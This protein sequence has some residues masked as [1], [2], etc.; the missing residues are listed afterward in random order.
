MTTPPTGTVTLLF[1]DIEGSTKLLQRAGDA[2]TDLLAVHRRLLREVFDAQNGY[3]VDTQGDAFFVAFASVRDAVAA[4]AGAQQALAAH[5]WP[6]HCEVSVRIGVHTGEPQLVEGAYVG[7]DV[8]H[9]ARVM[10]AGHGGQ[11]LVS[12]ATRELL[13]EAFELLDLGAHRLKD[14]SRPEHLYQVKIE[15]LRS[16]FPALKTLENRPTNL[17]A[18]PTALIG[19]DRQLSQLDSL[20]STQ[21]V[22][23]VTLTGP[24]GTGKTRLALATAAQMIDEFPNGVYFVSLA[25]LRDADL[26]TPAVLH[27]LGVREQPGEAAGETLRAY[28]AD[29]QMLLVLDNFEQVLSAAV[30]IASLLAGAPNVK[31]LVTSRAP[32]HLSG[33]RTYGV[34]PLTLPDLE[35]LPELAGLHEYEAVRLFVE[36]AQAARADFALTAG[37]APAVAEIC[38][39]LDGLPLALELAAARIRVLPPP[40]LLRRLDQRLKLLTGGSHDLDERQRTLRA[41]IEW[42]YELLDEQERM[43]LRRLGVFVGGCTIDAAE[44]V[45]NFDGELGLDVLDG[46]TSLLEMS[47]LRQAE[48]A[49]GEPRFSMLETI[50]DYARDALDSDDDGTAKAHA[51]WFASFARSAELRGPEQ[52][53]WW[54]RL[55]ADH[56]NFREAMHTFRHANQICECLRLASDLAEYSFQSGSISE[57]RD[58]LEVALAE[59]GDCT[60]MDRARAYAFASNLVF[61]QGP[62]ELALEHARRAFAL[63]NESGDDAVRAESLRSLGMAHTGMGDLEAAEACYGDCLQ[64]ARGRDELAPIASDVANNLADLA[65]ERG[66]LGAA[67]DLLE[68]AV[69]IGGAR[70]DQ[71][72]LATALTNL[73]VVSLQSG[74]FADA[75]RHLGE[76]LSFA[77]RN[78]LPAIAASALVG[79]AALAARAEDSRAAMSFLASADAI[80]REIGY[81]LHSVEQQLYDEARDTIQA[82]DGAEERPAGSDDTEHA[83]AWLTARARAGP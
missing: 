32:L 44:A 57:G 5:A 75:A 14:L 28:L 50:R 38:V 22:R 11:V 82:A 24:G 73:G 25:S 74:D 60:A 29:R 19:R 59:G 17:P 69:A 6:E 9:A 4:A 33:E 67:K 49:D 48:G 34:P 2:Y 70:D 80:T 53:A 79:A 39:R 65:L 8:H 12:H 23:L 68:Q 16:T 15:G 61:F 66:D 72:I 58:W 3:E 55:R 62:V 13:A 81:T 7:L 40:A 43:F 1:T 78:K 18:P 35:R 26:V 31:A 76:A 54:A 63:A 41:T 46:L 71:Y 47:L 10:A 52:E 56:L 21:E 45:C 20:L 42:S 30:D 51:E 37:N 36:R 77:R 27:A 64:I 83:I